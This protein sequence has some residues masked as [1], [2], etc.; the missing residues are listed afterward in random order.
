M[1]LYVVVHGDVKSSCRSLQIQYWVTCDHDNAG[2][3]TPLFGR[4]TAWEIW[5]GHWTA[6]IGAKLS[7]TPAV[8]VLLYRKYS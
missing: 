5:P 4:H 1:Y 2:G 7:D 3:S 6:T 8:Q